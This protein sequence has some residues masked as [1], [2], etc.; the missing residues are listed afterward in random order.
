MSPRKRSR[1][2]GSELVPHLVQVT[3]ASFPS[4]HA[5][6]SSAVYLTLALMLAEGMPRDGW[7]GRAR[8]GGRVLQPARRAD[9]DEPGVSRRALAERCAGGLVFRDGLGVVGLDGGSVAGTQGASKR[10]KWGRRAYS[11]LRP[12]KF[13]DAANEV[14][15][16]C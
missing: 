1:A 16:E 3:N 11:R 4:G 6:I 12:L 2:A 13:V 15:K 7:R 8:R 9:R 10:V 5:M 14:S